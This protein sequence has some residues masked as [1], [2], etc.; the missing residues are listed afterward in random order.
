MPKVRRAQMSVAL[1]RHLNARIKQRE[2]SGTQLILLARWLDTNPEV[3]TG[4]WFKRF[5]E[6]V[7]CGEGELI[8]T[9]LRPG[10][11]AD[12]EEVC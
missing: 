9:F 11:I 8:K 4:K 10:Q 12:G 2:I 5:P 6:M 3:P 7:A 1:L